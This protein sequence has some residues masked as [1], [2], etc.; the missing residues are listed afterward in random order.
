[1]QL[2][3]HYKT[4]ILSDLHLGMP[5][6]KVNELIAFLRSVTCERLVLNGDIIDGW[7][8]D[9]HPQCKWRSELRRILCTIYEMMEDRTSDVIYMYGN[10]DD[11][12]ERYVG[13]TILGISVLRDFTIQSGEMRYF[14]THGDCFDTVNRKA[15]WLSKV[16]ASCYEFLLF[17]NGYYNRCRIL[18]GK[19]PY[20]F[21]HAIKVWTRKLVSNFTNFEKQIT[22][23]AVKNDY[24]GVICGHIHNPEDTL[25]GNVRY[26]N[27][28]DWIENKSVLVEDEDQYW[29]VLWV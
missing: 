9:K 29:K 7:Y 28:G 19:Q 1:M 23:F 5:H 15:T 6:S 18:F 16:G 10:H 26:L 27:S 14:V 2:K 24:D 3:Q 8:I 21:A 25:L 11:F 13:K 17:L 20:S 12:M 22:D 4:I